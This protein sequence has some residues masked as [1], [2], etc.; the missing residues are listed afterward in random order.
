MSLPIVVVI[1]TLVALIWIGLKYATPQA[2]PIS[3]EDPL[4]VDAIRRAR[5]TV[6][7]MLALLDAGRDVWLKFPIDTTG[8]PE[9]VWGRATGRSG[10]TLYC[11]IETPTVARSGAPGRGSTEVRAADIEDWQVELEDGT[12]RGGFTTLA[13]AEIA[14]RDGQPVPSHV[15]DLLTRIRN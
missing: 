8:P 3:P 9:H 10:D 7:E 1:L 5:S 15:R 2:T 13:Q 14:K 11:R 6:P 12:V 4:W